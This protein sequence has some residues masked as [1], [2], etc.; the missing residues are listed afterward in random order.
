[1]KTTRRQFL[2]NA[3][4]AAAAAAGAKAVR[5]TPAAALLPAPGRRVA[6]FGGGVAG[7]TAAHELVERGF[8]VVVFE[9][10]HLGGKAWSI[11]VPGSG[12]RMN[13]SSETPI[14]CSPS[15]NS[16]RLM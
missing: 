13:T 12:G 2:R 15:Q 6:I 11:G 9:Q 8:E 4:I 3:G 1:M 14:F 16:T 5:G 10:D 7:L